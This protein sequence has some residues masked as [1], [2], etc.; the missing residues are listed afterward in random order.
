MQEPM[1]NTERID[2]S[3]LLVVLAALCVAVGFTPLAWGTTYYVDSISGSDG[4]GG[5][6]PSTAWETLA[7]VNATTFAP[8]DQILLKAG[9]VWND[10]RL[11]PKGSGTPGNLIVIDM[12]GTGP[13]PLI[14]GNGV[15]QEALLLYNQEYWEISNLEVTNYDPAGPGVNPLRQGVRVLGEDAGTL[16]HVHLLHLDVHDVNGS[17]TDGRDQGKCNAGILFDVEGSTTPTLFNDVLIEGCSVY[18]CERSGI[19]LWTNWGRSC[20]QASPSLH[21]NVVIRSNVVDNIAGDG[22]NV[23]QTAGALAEH[24][25]VSRSCYWTDKANAALW[26]WASDDAIIQYNEVYD[27]MQTWDG[28]AFDIDGCCLRC[29]YQYNYSHDNDGGFLMIIGAPDCAGGGPYS[30]FCTDNHFRYN[31]SQRDETRLLRF[32]GK[33]DNN[34]VYNNTIYVG[35]TDPLIVET[36]PC[37]SPAQSPSNSYIYNNIIYNTESPGAAYDVSHGIN[38]VFDYNAF[39]GYHPA[40]EPADPN[41]LTSDP[42]LVNPGSAS[43]GRASCEGY[44][45]R[46]GSPCIDSGMTIPSSGGQDFWGNPVPAGGG[47]DRG[48]HEFSGGPSK[49]LLEVHPNERGQ[50]PGGGPRIGGQPWQPSGLGPG[51]WY[52]MKVYEFEGGANLWIQVAAQCFS[53]NQ[54]AV[55]EGDKLMMKVDG[56]VPSDVWGIQSGPAA[57]QWKGNV[58]N[59]E[60]RTLEFHVTGLTPGRHTIVFSADETPIIWWV[61]VHDL[62]RTEVP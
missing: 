21:T 50:G 47:P 7:N 29:I 23:H 45:L 55:G 28:M 9:C 30:K 27:S 42:K 5:T 54:N 31:I 15:E 35:A 51:S 60:R 32:I 3:L 24:N 62:A 48:A 44:K 18:A 53:S 4:Y 26:T 41:K 33:V 19:K 59:G 25:V 20:T 1:G 36:G 16:D 8:G 61:K 43:L 40:S 14:N 46:A 2:Q 13:K 57:Y 11:Y 17:I 34:Y 58:D 38:Y 39:Y 6:T 12:Y 22:I 49:I 56:T 52:K 37:G 10:Q